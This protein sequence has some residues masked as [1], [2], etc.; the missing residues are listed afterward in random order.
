MTRKPRAQGGVRQAERADRAVIDIGSNTVRLVVYSGPRRTPN[1]WLNEKVT[2]RLGKDLSTTGK[3][4][5]K[6]IEMALDGLAR[7]TTILKDLEIADVQCVATAAVRE[8]KNGP[9]FLKQVEN[10]GLEPRLLSGEEE[11]NI[12]A[13][14]VIGAFPGAKGIVTDLGGGS[15]ELVAIGE[16]TCHHGISTPLGTLRLPALREGGERAFRKAINKELSAAGWAEGYEGPLYLVGGT[17][18]ALAAY[19]MH[20]ADY[21]LTDPHAYR[22]SN[23]DGEKVAK[24]LSQMAPEKLANIP[25]ISS[26]RAAG[27]PDAAAMLRVL[28]S[29]LKPDGLVISGWGLREGLL[30]ERLE[31]AAREQDPLI[32]A[33]THFATPRGASLN[34]AT[35]IA[36]WTSRVVTP[37]GRGTERLRLAAIL[38][39]MAQVRIE[40]NM[41]LKHSFEWAVDKR[42][43]GLGHNGRALIGM[44][45]RG[46]CSKP[47]PPEELLQLASDEELREAASWGLAFRLCRRIGAGSRASMLTSRLS[48]EDGKLVLWLD[49]S[50]ANLASELVIED[51][52]ILANWLGCEPELRLGDPAQH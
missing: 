12:S 9:Q 30:F 41:R 51:L 19:A 29:T 3:L 2:A 47:E 39:A 26:S 21:P 1:V 31:P 28:L 34:H 18:R 37:N 38:L 36:G 10:F 11:A 52:R 17:W 42:W 35:M 5:A 13:M 25:G 48:R 44:A 6:S 27:L 23:A 7:F 50:R 46:A 49:E 45:L 8:A 4:P 33:V 22:L 24:K 20:R 14:G 43:P 40:P 32:T 15:L 16:G